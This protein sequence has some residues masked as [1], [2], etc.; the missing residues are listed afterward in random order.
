MHSRGLSINT[1]KLIKTL[2][3][4]EKVNW[5][6]TS[7]R[8]ICKLYSTRLNYFHISLLSVVVFSD[9]LSTIVV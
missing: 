9:S 7:E 1:V 5:A 2:C 8:Y 6:S 4:L 3:V